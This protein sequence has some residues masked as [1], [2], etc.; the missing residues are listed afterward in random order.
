LC[1]NLNW[2]FFDS[3]FFFP[4]NSQ[5]WWLFDSDFQNLGTRNY[6]KNQRTMPTLPAAPDI[7]DAVAG[8]TGL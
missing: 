2:Q 3:D 6:L 8:L 7:G 5:N 1:D 4:S